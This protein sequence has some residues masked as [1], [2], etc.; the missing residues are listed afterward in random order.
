[1]KSKFRFLLSLGFLILLSTSGLL[2]QES[3]D[4]SPLAMALSKLPYTPQIFGSYDNDFFNA[5]PIYFVDINSISTAYP[6]TEA[7]SSFN[8]SEMNDAQK[9]WFSVFRNQMPSR[10]LATAMGSG[11]ATD[12][13][14]NVFDTK[15]VLSYAS[16]PANPLLLMGDWDLDAVRAALTDLSYTPIEDLSVELWCPYEGAC[17]EGTKINY[18]ALNPGNPFGGDLGRS[19]PLV[20]ADGALWGAAADSVEGLAMMYKFDE[21]PA[22]TDLPRYQALLNVLVAEDETLLQA[23]IM[24]GGMLILVNSLLAPGD[25]LNPDPLDPETLAAYQDILINR[26]GYEL[27]LWADIVDQES[28]IFRVAYVYTDMESAEAMQ[29][30]LE[31]AFEMTD[32]L[33]STRTGTPV[34]E[35]LETY[36]VDGISSQLIESGDY[37]VLLMD[38]KTPKAT[39]EDLLSLA[40]NQADAPA[41]TPPS[42]LYQLFNTAIFTRDYPLLSWFTGAS[43]SENYILEM[44]SMGALGEEAQQALEEM[45][46]SSPR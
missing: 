29:A 7:L 23:S 18:D 9:A 11:S 26:P 1:M 15:Q 10:N 24:D 39:V 14:F 44:A 17:G 40:A 32:E 37:A 3:V 5:N 46:E 12:L 35:V 20:L 4:E 36:H 34:S 31:T 19:F 6:G 28:Q 21:T 38:L 45:A 13:G 25:P 42:R 43:I 30:S 2:A 16:P 22:L 27:M 33:I 41:I 8:A